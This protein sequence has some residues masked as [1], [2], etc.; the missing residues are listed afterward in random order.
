MAQENCR[1]ALVLP[2]RLSR[3]AQ[4]L[5]FTAQSGQGS[6]RHTWEFPKGLPECLLF[7]SHVFLIGRRMP[8]QSPAVGSNHFKMHRASRATRG[9]QVLK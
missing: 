4:A 8:S 3:D 9:S 5:K 6:C 2:P 1:D 7:S